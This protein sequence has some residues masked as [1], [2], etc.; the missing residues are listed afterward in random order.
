MLATAPEAQS[1]KIEAPSIASLRDDDR[2]QEYR[3]RR[4]SMLRTLRSASGLR[5]VRSC[6]R[7]I[8]GD[9]VTL[10]AGRSGIAHVGG[11]GRCAS[12]WSCPVCSPT[13]RRARA[14]EVDEGL[15]RHLATTPGEGHAGAFLTLT[16]AH[17]R[18]DSLAMLMDVL[19][20][21]WRRLQQTSAY[22]RRAKALGGVGLIKAV[23]VTL[24]QSG[25]HPHLHLVA[26]FGRRTD[27]EGLAQF[28]TWLAAAWAAQIDSIAGRYVHPTKG[29]DVRALTETGTDGTA[30][31]D[32]LVKIDGGW[33]AAMELLRG[34]LKKAG[35]GGMSAPQLLRL[36]CEGGESW[37]WHRW[38][39]YETATKGRRMLT[40]SRG[41]RDRLGMG[42]E[43]TDEE[44]AVALE[45][46]EGGLVTLQVHGGYWGRLLD[47]GQAA[48]YLS[49]FE[50]AAQLAFALCNW[51]G[52]S[53]P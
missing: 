29:V 52:H 40:W 27:E 33:G 49:R 45:A 43:M 5:S 20:A 11:V 22:R 7:P 21:A 26:L 50:V 10:T 9:G 32:Y 4:W 36:A 46:P 14:T 41:L 38:W 13:V 3:S 8:T 39:E 51:S 30:L 16:F 19:L 34:D 17:E 37:A 53:P 6:M 24:G 15:A 12:P 1:N 25:W 23:E 44:A 18:E 2:R 28:R 31:G 48:A 42:R 35:R 47:H